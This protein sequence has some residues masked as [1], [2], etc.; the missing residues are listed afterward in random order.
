ML[1]RINLERSASMFP[2]TCQKTS[3]YSASRLLL[4][5]YCAIYV[6]FVQ[7]KSLGK[8]ADD[9]S[10]M[11][12]PK[13]SHEVKILHNNKTSGLDLLEIDS[14]TELPCNQVNVTYLGRKM[15]TEVMFSGVQSFCPT[16]LKYGKER[17]TSLNHPGKGGPTIID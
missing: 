2:S 17:Y 1:Q 10:G 3:S 14:K 12:Q 6:L 8:G 11:I 7:A 16:N 5:P 9:K 13:S 4:K 15:T